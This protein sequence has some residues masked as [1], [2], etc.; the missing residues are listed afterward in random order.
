[1]CILPSLDEL[2]KLHLLRQ[3]NREPTAQLDDQVKLVLLEIPLNPMVVASA[4]LVE[5]TV[6]S[7]VVEVSSRESLEEEP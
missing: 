4:T 2:S 1:V 5:E 3:Q 7:W 6:V